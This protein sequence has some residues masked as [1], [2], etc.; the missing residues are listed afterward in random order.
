MSKVFKA[1]LIFISPFLLKYIFISTYFSFDL[2]E[3]LEDIIF[4]FIVAFAFKLK[5]FI[6]I[7]FKYMLLFLYL[8]YFFIEGASYMA[9]NSNF[10]AS[11]MYLLIESSSGELKEFV[12]SYSS[13]FVIVYFAL[14]TLT[15]FVII[16][17]NFNRKYRI[18]SLLGITVILLLVVLLKTTGLIEKNAYHN[19]VRG[20]YGYIELQNNFSLETNVKEEDVVVNS[21]NDILVVV[22]GE[23]T[24]RRHMQLYGYSRETTPLLNAIKDSL[25]VYKN[26]ISTDV[27][28]LKSVPKMLTSLNESI[29]HDERLNIIDIFNKAGYLTY[30]LSNQLPISYH[31][32]AISK[33][34]SKSYY[35]KFF[36]HANEVE[37]LSY[38]EV[39]LPEFDKVLKQNGKKVIFIRLLGTHF[40]YKN[41]YPFD[42]NKFSKIGGSF[43]TEIKNQYDNAVFYNDFIV[44]SIIKKL[45]GIKG[46]N[47]LLYTSDHGENVFDDGDFF[48]RNEANL[49]KSM[50]EIPFFIWTSDSFELPKDFQFD[51]NRK[52]MTDHTYESLGHLLGVKHKDMDFN[53]SIFS[54]SFK[55]RERNVVNGVNFD[56]H[57]FKS[58]E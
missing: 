48:G 37:T 28:T 51:S 46:N 41:R 2:G 49:T 55:E 24:T 32:N 15:F 1:Y 11:F 13:I 35:L 14:L 27:F 52:F 17:F 33:I 44:Y 26:V 16:R 25:F 39:L 8:L 31:D 43:K 53:K 57:F 6:N 10:T 4:C 38:D 29:K 50:F 20:V 30:W 42:F 18:N 19:I 5:I 9:V 58:N 56:T 21:N 3:I 36:I 34:A 7:F 40:D 22:L 45:K 54:K 23:S 12:Q 47:A